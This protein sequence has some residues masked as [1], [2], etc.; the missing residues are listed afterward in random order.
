MPAADESIVTQKINE[1]V[2]SLPFVNVDDCQIYYR[3]DGGFDPDDNRP[4]L[5]LSH[6]L[7][8]DHGQWDLQ[9]PALLPHFRLVRYDLRGHGASG[10]PPGDYSIEQL[11]RDVLA[12]VDSLQISQFAFCGLSIGGMIGQWLA[13]SAPDRVTHVVL[14]NT[15]SRLAD[16]GPM[17]MR[18]AKVLE[19]GMAAVE[20][21]VMQRYFSRESLAENPPAV[22][23]ARHTHRSTAPVG[24]AGC[25]AAIAGMDQTR[26]LPKI[27]A[28]TLVINGE[29]DMAT[30]WSGNG[31]ILVASIKG[32]K[33]VH[34]PTAHI[35]NL[36][37]PRS[38]NAALFDFLMSGAEEDPFEAGL[39]MRRSVLGAPYVDRSIKQATDF[40]RDFQHLITRYAW[41][42]VWTRPGLDRPTRRL[43]VL[44][45]AA[46][47]GRWEE[48]RLHLR[49]GLD[50]E[51]EPCDVKE[52]LLATAV[53]AGVPAALSGFKI[54]MEEMREAA[55]ASSAT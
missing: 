38:F 49:A 24:Y 39:A 16:P 4:V 2:R 27:R 42:S 35:S 6:S 3:L 25:C 21:M 28:A 11:G 29:R 52:A 41:G 36:E 40:S 37:R 44:V 31:E 48:Y 7:G 18:R 43:L 15:T 30:P 51:L 19:G 46:T 50:H 45:I 22:R 34:L 10:A 13:A 55:S 32:A 1:G 54:A 47:S 23:W 17:E 20:D 5:V 26:L 33:V 9:V 53:Y 14:A 12:I 8:L